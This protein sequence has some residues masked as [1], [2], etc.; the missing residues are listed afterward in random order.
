MDFSADAVLALAPDDASAK[1]ARGLTSPAKWPT[2]GA[3]DRAVWGECQG[4]GS[5]P[6]Q[7]Q[8]D[9]S[10]PTFKCSCPSRKFPCKHGLALLLIRASEPKLFANGT[11]APLWV[12]EWLA[13]RQ[14]RV[15]R[16]EQRAA[17]RAAAP[18]PSPEAIEKREAQR[19][20]KIKEG[21]D[22]LQLW[23]SDQVHLGLAQL[24]AGSRGDFYAMAARLVDQQA[25][26]L[27]QRLRD[28]ADEIGAA[29][30]WP[31]RVLRCF[32]QLQLAIEAT[33]RRAALDPAALADLR[34]ALGWT[35]NKEDVLAQGERLRDEWLALAVA[36][37]QRDAKLQER[38]VWLQGLATGQRALLADFAFGGSGFDAAWIAGHVHKAEVAFYPGAASLRALVASQ[39]EVLPGPMPLREAA[40]EWENAAQRWSRN[41]WLQLQP[42]LIPQAAL[43]RSPEAWSLE[44]GAG[45]LPLRITDES[46]WALAAQTGGHAMPLFGE[47]DGT[48]LTPL[49]VWTPD[50]LWT[51][52]SFA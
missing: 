17:E 52:A 10:G 21:L 18:P 37:E 34:L 50:G 7:S 30:D 11:T 24:G 46:A 44:T 16:K 14:E 42:L 47:W 4:S 27:A 2:L 36:V 15:E 12:N 29:P 20:T 25:P 31:A 48:R 49:T 26:S 19:W 38:R 23:M 9:L 51:N 28:V 3:D 32:G 40:T 8:V 45:R 22:Q 39:E 5:K 13:V 6:Y 1:A 35:L 33:R 43:T 41:P